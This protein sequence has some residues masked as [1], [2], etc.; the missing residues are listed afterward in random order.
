MSEPM[1]PGRELDKLVAEIM[2]WAEVRQNPE[3]PKFAIDWDGF[4]PRDISGFRSRIPD[5]ST[6]SAA[7]WAAREWL[8][9][10]YT[11]GGVCLVRDLDNS[12]SVVTLDRGELDKT[13][14]RGE[15]YPHAI[16]LAVV[17]TRATNAE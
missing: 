16:A 14:A 5:F 12:P 3:Y 15:S 11:P 4:T 13:L 17:A 9:R 2:G 10:Y 6:E 7:A 8:E 1:K